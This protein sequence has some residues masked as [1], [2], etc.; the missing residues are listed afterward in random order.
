M[1]PVSA[2]SVKY[3]NSTSC[4][5]IPLG[6]R[7]VGSRHGQ[8]RKDTYGRDEG[9]R[10]WSGKKRKKCSVA[11]NCRSDDAVTNDREST[12]FVSSRDETRPSTEVRTRAV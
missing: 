2:R 11:S 7:R 3:G 1:R 6:I 4:I 12:S 10:A 8:A 5:R 9:R